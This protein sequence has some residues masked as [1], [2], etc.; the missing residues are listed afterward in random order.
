MKKSWNFLRTT[1][2]AKIQR[3]MQTEIPWVKIMKIIPNTIGRK[4][5]SLIYTTKKVSHPIWPSAGSIIFGISN[6]AAR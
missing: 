6:K 5:Y 3:A 2:E 1:I 4:Q